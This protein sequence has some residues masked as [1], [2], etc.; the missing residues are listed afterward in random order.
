MRPSPAWSRLPGSRRC[1]GC[2]RRDTACRSARRIP[3]HS[4][5]NIDAVDIR[6]A[7]AVIQ[8]IEEDAIASIGWKLLEKLFHHV[9]VDVH[10]VSQLVVGQI[11]APDG[12]GM[13]RGGD[14][15]GLLITI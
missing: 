4:R 15:F 12:R 1:A 10:G 8:R 9:R 3:Q 2:N 6:L 7:L 11:P 14:L 13:T 5:A